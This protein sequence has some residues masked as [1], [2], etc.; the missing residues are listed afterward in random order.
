METVSG[1]S[2]V[3]ESRGGCDPGTSRGQRRSL[4]SCH[5]NKVG[6]AGFPTLPGTHIKAY[7]SYDVRG[8][9]TT[10]Q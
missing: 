4:R 10:A 2:K 1:Q 9:I 6:E 7:A 8:G 5:L 3:P